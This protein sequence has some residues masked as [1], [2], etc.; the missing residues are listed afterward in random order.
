MNKET[1]VAETVKVLTHSIR[2]LRELY[3]A[4]QD[5]IAKLEAKR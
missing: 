2:E 4:L 1:D 3:E 5:R